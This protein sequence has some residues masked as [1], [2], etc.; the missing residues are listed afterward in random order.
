M[1]ARK[2]KPQTG[3]DPMTVALAGVLLLA[4]FCS[5]RV[6]HA[7]GSVIDLAVDKDTYATFIVEHHD[8]TKDIQSDNVRLAEEVNQGRAKLVDAQAEAIVMMVACA[9][10]AVALGV[11]LWKQRGR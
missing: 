5:W 8:D 9:G 3:L 1:S 2:V 4:A 10:I 11:R 7:A 6:Y